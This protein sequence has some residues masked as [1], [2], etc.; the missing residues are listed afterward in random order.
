[1]KVKVTEFFAKAKWMIITDGSL[2]LKGQGLTQSKTDPKTYSATRKA[3]NNL[4]TDTRL[5][6]EDLRF[7]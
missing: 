2:E 5:V 6:I 4:K 7:D 3:I 1:M